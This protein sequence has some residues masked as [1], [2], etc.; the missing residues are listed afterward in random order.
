MPALKQ[1]A[2]FNEHYYKKNNLHTASILCKLVKEAKI[3]P[4]NFFIPLL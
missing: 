1:A 4:N 3:L 2:T